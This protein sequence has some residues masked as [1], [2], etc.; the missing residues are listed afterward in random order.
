[1]VAFLL[2]DGAHTVHEIQRLLKVGEGEVFG[3]V[4]LIDYLPARHLGPEAFQLRTTKR[5]RTTAAR[6]TMFLG[7]AHETIVAQAGARRRYRPEEPKPGSSQNRKGPAAA[8]AETENGE[9][10]IQGRGTLDAQPAHH[11]ETR[12]VHDGKILVSKGSPDL[13]GCF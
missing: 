5:R 4:V 7:E 8:R 1:M 10:V 9:V 6:D 11:S 2:R 13:P 12:A 3:Q